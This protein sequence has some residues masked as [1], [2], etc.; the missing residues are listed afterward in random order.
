M[1]V[2]ECLGLEQ[3]L[4]TALEIARPGQAVGRVGTPVGFGNC[5]G[6]REF[7]RLSARPG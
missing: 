6:V 7:S 5:A 2:V 3:A 4:D 1:S